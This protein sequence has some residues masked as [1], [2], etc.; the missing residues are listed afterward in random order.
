[1]SN[2]DDHFVTLCNLWCEE[3][4][5]ADQLVELQA[6]LRS[7]RDLRGMFVEYIQLHGQLAWDAGVGVGSQLV[8]FPCQTRILS[9]GYVETSPDFTRVES[10]FKPRIVVAA[11]A[12]LLFAGIATISFR[13]T[14]AIQLVTNVFKSNPDT[15]SGPHNHGQELPHLDAEQSV[16]VQSLRANQLEP[17]ELNG[18]QP[19]VLVPNVAANSD[20]SGNPDHVSPVETPFA[21]DD[22][23]I[24]QIDHLIAE[25]WSERNVVQADIADD[26]EWVRR[27]YL[28]LTGRIPTVGEASSFVARSS[29]RKRAKL[30]DS[31][32]ED[33]RFAEHL[34]VTWTNLLIGR[35]N[36]RDVDQE[37]LFGFLQ[38]Q[39]RENRPWMETVGDL[40]AAEG[41]SDQNGATNFL[42]AHLNDQ[43]TP[44]TAV[45]ARLFLGQ[46]VQCT[47]C[48]DHPFAKDRRQDE[49][50]SLNAFFK[51]AE[52]RSITVD[53]ADGKSHSV[54][55]LTDS[56]AP[57]M[58]F[59]D[60][61]R[62]QKKAVLPE[63]DGHAMS[64]DDS[65][66]R[67]TELVR[68]LA[69]DSRQMIAHAMV[70]RTW[71]QVFGYGFT[72]PIDD[73]G[74][75]TPVSHPDVLD[76]VASS[77]ADSNYDVRRLMRWLTLSQTFQLSS[78]QD[79]QSFSVD[80]P[81]D[82]GT[83]LFSRA[84]P[85]SM[86]PEQFYDS[87]R[88]AI[89]SAAD[90]PVD[91]SIGTKHRREWVEQFVRSYGTD[92]NDEQLVFEFNIAQ[93]L[94]MMNGE[95]IQS[96][97]PLTAAEVTK[98]ASE[99]ANGVTKSL[100]RIAMATL[101]REPSAGEEK[102]FRSRYRVLSRSLPADQAI[103][104]A[105]ED[106]LWAYLNSS[107]FTSVH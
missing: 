93:A 45:T 61:L 40:I 35:S 36:A 86:A 77:F 39:F 16:V 46:Q 6:V 43:A 107:E 104:T 94:L 31:L 27:C 13:G 25:G 88:I 12:C 81:Q 41:R 96:A 19:N 71:A 89:R 42:L 55:T 76:L 91:S 60:T 7:D 83:P 15:D 21:D 5:S 69:A 47:Q 18:V 92:E 20:A 14:S 84:Y 63:F 58:T 99:G 85:R 9:Q 100:E 11:A 33:P 32:L 52:R 64:A 56:G 44:A 57:G 38:R 1:M 105:T 97:I 75:H 28:T 102:V 78:Y 66:S 26:H 4:L 101:N 90:Q 79:E 98:S 72:N 49:F 17:L 65:S 10:S 22:S 54:W 48:H 3:Q 106:M 24:S 73:L 8:D 95:D 50:W 34:S 53:S 37:A 59:Y 29:P 68:L 82:G 62:G 2:Q 80:D 70:N 67:R 23:I 87:I 103:R 30:V 74:P 51:Q